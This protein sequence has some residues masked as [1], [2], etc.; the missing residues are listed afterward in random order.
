MYVEVIGD[1]I[2]RA[3]NLLLERKVIGGEEVIIKYFGINWNKEYLISWL[4]KGVERFSL[5]YLL[6]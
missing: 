6:E 1:Y 4:K 5:K 2:W 3:Y